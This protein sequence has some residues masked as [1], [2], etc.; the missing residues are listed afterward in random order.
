MPEWQSQSHVERYCKYHVLFVPNYRRR[1]IYGAR[2]VIGGILGELCQQQGVVIVEGHAM[3][4]PIHLC[5]SVPPNYS[6]AH[7]VGNRS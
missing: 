2:R 6:V 4:D 5:L 1:S 3:P 7:T